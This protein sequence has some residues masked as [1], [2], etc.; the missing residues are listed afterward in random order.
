LTGLLNRRGFFELAEQ[1]LYTAQVERR[2]LGVIMLDID[3]FKQI[4][5][6]HVHPFGDAVLVEVASRLRASLR[7]DD[8]AGR[9]G[10]D[11]LLVVLHEANCKTARAIARCCWQAI[12]G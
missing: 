11:E 1:S 12:I 10:G 5:D 3:H 6:L 4:N 2:T 9:Y 8:L 7:S